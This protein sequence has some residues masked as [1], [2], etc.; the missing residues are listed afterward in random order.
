MIAAWMLWSVGAG[1]L[2]LVG[3]L[4]AE[5]LVK[6]GRRWVWLAAAAG[7]VVLPALRMASSGAGAEG[8]AVP[9][10]P[11]ML[12]PVTMTV[13]RD[14]TLHSLDAILLLTW[15]GL[16]TALLVTAIVAGA[17]FLRRR[18]SWEPGTLLGK[19]VLW[20]RDTGPAVVG[21]LRSR[22]VLPGW[23]RGAG[24][25]R[26]Q[27]VLAHEEEHQRAGD[28]HARFICGVLLIVFPWNPAL[29]F[30]YRRLNLAIELDCD[31]RVMNRLPDQRRLYG[32]LLLRVGSRNGALPGLAVAA[33]AEQRSLLER[34]IRELLSRAPEVRMAQAAFLVFGAVLVV[35]LALSIPGITGEGPAEPVLLHP[36]AE[37]VIVPPA[38]EE[39]EELDVSARPVFTPYTVKP[40]YIK[41]PVTFR[42]AG[43]GAGASDG[44][45]AEAEAEAVRRQAVEE[46]R[47]RAAEATAAERPR[48]PPLPVIMPY[49]MKPE[50]TNP[51]E[52]RAALEREYPPLLR[53][54]GVGGTTIIWFFINERGEVENERVATT[55]GSDALDEAALRVAPVFRFT[56]AE[57]RG[58]AVPVWV[59]LPITFT[60][61]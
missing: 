3:A 35:G 46:A 59:Q 9:V 25:A 14:S 8:L 44:Q 22:I 38:R 53:D 42:A 23:V 52:I 30:Q 10:A 50:Y 31:Q 57:N 15:V 16:S 33:L 54:A 27:L 7:T 40:D 13:S 1:L 39:A 6:G 29:W 34:R 41:L 58:E 47:E 18:A 37:V 20:S 17:R 32:D 60:A 45:A 4:A 5:R 21:L 28:V 19:D 11:I 51:D 55:S 49:T 24:T 48:R 43:A 12:D 36:E 26:Q 56:P 2:F 61:R